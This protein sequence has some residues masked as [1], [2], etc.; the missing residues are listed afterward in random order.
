MLKAKPM[1]NLVNK[2]LAKRRA[3]E[4]IRKLALK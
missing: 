1:A 3:T 2:Q 4:Q